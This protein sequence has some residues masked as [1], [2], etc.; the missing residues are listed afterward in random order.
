MKQKNFIGLALLLA[1]VSLLCMTCVKEKKEDYDAKIYYDVVGEGY[2]FMC[3]SIGNILYPVEGAEISVQPYLDYGE[4]QLN[5]FY[6]EP[7]IEFY[8]TDENG[9]YQVPF[10]KRTKRRDV[11]M[12]WFSVNIVGEWGW[13]VSSPNSTFPINVDAVKHAHDKIV[14]IDNVIYIDIHN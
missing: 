4:R 1:S 2:V 11:A 7:D 8:F 5:Y 13:W 3:D 6:L 10:L 9:K 12:Y 14:L